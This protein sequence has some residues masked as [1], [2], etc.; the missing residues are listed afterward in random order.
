MRA[1]HGDLRN[2]LEKVV[3]QARRTAERGATAAV[4]RLAVGEPKP[5]DHM[6][7]TD[8]ELRRKLRARGRV[9]GDERDPHSGS[10]EINRLVREMAYQH[11]HRML[12]ARFLA[13]NDLLMHPSGVAVTLKECEELAREEGAPDGWA[14]AERYAARMLPQ[15]FRP[16]DPVLQVSFSPEDQQELESLLS[17]LSPQV[18][19]ADDSLGWTYQFWQ[20]ERKDEVNA[21]N[22]KVGAD[23]LPA[24]TQLFTEDYMVQ[25]LLD[26]TLGAW[27]AGKYLD[28]HP[29]V[30]DDLSLSEEEL[31][32]QIA[33]KGCSFEY[34]RFLPDGAEADAEDSLPEKNV[35]A[36]GTFERW[37]QEAKDLKVMDP[38]CG[39]GHFH[40]AGLKKLVPM[41]M[42]EEG[43]SAREAC[44][45]VLRDNLYGLEIDQR[46]TQIAAFALALAAWKYPGTG[47]YRELPEL[48]IACSGIAVSA[49]EQEW[50]E[51]AGN[52]SRLR[53]GMK[54]LYDL[55]REAPT[56]GSLIN[57]SRVHGD[58]LSAGINELRA[59]LHEAL[60]KE[61]EENNV[62]ALELGVAARG[63][64]RATHFLTKGY[65]LVA[66]NVPYLSR[67]KQ[68]LLLQ[69][70]G[71]EQ[72]AHSKKDLSTMFQSRC[73]RLCVTGGKTALVISQH[74]MY[75][76]THEKFRKYL[77]KKARWDLVARLGS[78]AFDTISGEV[79][80][81]SLLIL[82]QSA[83]GKQNQVP[84]LDAQNL[85][86][87]RDKMRLLRSRKLYSVRQEDL[88]KNPKS[89][90]SLVLHGNS[91]QLAK[92]ATYHNG[93]QTG[94]APRFIRMF[95]EVYCDGDTWEFQQS[96]VE[97]TTPFGGMQKVLLW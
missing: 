92:Y 82:T 26:N 15:I 44:D 32:H 40:V 75:L 79:V 86:Q 36:A 62:E 84:G 52:D 70:F 59:A 89:R 93:I 47:G 28:K 97:S 20:S 1:L 66:T 16:D 25:F 31:R 51:L 69:K 18:F 90:I 27:W 37:P 76:S 85:N 81:V 29:D 39:S 10:Q 56:L 78:S 45:A 41:R 58:V 57:P 49:E 53:D 9:L 6:T 5:Y 54:K 12:F 3:K 91:P 17:D 68:S 72:F 95:W 94:D 60:S 7:E 42:E 2:Q 80:N 4:K 11:W 48:N 8:R 21:S 61:E 96:T 14:L 74:W 63:I 64:A 87:P 77:L 33:P 35:P 88:L 43:L 65:N 55:F 67:G 23:E 46:C 71:E 30:A 22:D 34:L 19:K 38:C 83:N 73:L 50:L 13:E 24:V